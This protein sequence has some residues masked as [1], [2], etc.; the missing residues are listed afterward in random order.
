MGD[1]QAGPLLSQIL[2]DLQQA[3]DVGCEDRLGSSGQEVIG[4]ASP[5]RFGHVRLGQIVAPGRTA[6]KFAFVQGNQ[7]EPWDHFEE[8][9][10]LLAD[11]LSVAQMAGIVIDRL[12]RQGMLR[13]DR[14]QVVQEL[15]D[16]L[17]L[18]SEFV[19]FPG[20]WRIV[21]QMAVTLEHG[22]APGSVGDDRVDFSQ[23]AGSVSD[24]SLRKERP[25]IL[26]AERLGRL[27]LGGM[28]V[29][30]AAAALIARNPHI[31]AVLL[32]DPGGAARWFRETW[33]RQRSP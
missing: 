23:R 27:L 9:P 17:D 8:L 4:L 25:A 24:R 11:L 29:K 21:Q 1:P 6:A 5:R 10:R 33:H 14:A 26:L 12:D 20:Q 7:L 32:Q 30:G 16:V 19:A 15:A 31:A 18:V 2:A 13:L 22:P 3:A 28:I